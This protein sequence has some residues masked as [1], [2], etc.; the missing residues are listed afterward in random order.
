MLVCTKHF[1]VF[2]VEQRAQIQ[3]ENFLC[4]HAFNELKYHRHNRGEQTYIP[5]PD[6]KCT[7]RM[8]NTR[9]I[10][11][12]LPC[13]RGNTLSFGTAASLDKDHFGASVVVFETPASTE[14]NCSR[15][16][17]MMEK[18]MLANMYGFL[19]SIS[20]FSICTL[21]TGPRQ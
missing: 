17:E 5:R 11:F 19:V 8:K 1:C 16:Y 14:R 7:K 13:L 4:L 20:R 21:G 9:R 3:V 18:Y 12:G 6:E 15:I 2:R 10:R